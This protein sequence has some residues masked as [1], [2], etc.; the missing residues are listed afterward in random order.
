MEKQSFTQAH[1]DTIAIIGST[2]GVNIAIAAI[3]ISM[4]ASNTH[5]I[6][7]TNSRIDSMCQVLMSNAGL[8]VPKNTKLG[9]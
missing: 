9:E 7:A 4:W 8:S 5:R 1:G 2:L 6:D 3:M